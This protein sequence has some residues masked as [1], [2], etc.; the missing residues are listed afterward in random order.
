VKSAC[1]L[2]VEVLLYFMYNISK[3]IHGSL[4]TDLFYKMYVAGVYIYIYIYMCVCVCYERFSFPTSI[5]LALFLSKLLVGFVF[6]LLHICLSSCQCFFPYIVH[7]I[8]E[9][10]ILQ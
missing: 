10:I 6:S 4:R 3:C 2:C 8:I 1:P 5:S 9:E 7:F